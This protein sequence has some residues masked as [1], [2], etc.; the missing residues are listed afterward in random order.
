MTHE[1]KLNNYRAECDETPLKLGT[2]D[3][4][5]IEQL[6]VTLGEGWDGLVVTAT[7]V[8][9]YKGTRMGMS[10]DGMINVPP[11]ATQQ[12]CSLCNPGKIVFVGTGDGVQRITTNLLYYVDNHAKI[13]GAESQPTPDEF[14]QLT[15]EYQNRLDKA[16]PPDG[17]PGQV[18]T[19]TADGNAWQAPQGGGGGAG[20]DGGY[21]TPSIRQTTE[22]TAEFSWA[23]SDDTMPPVEPVTL[24]L[25]QGEPG[26]DGISAGFGTIS[27][28]ATAL[29]PGQQP[30]VQASMDGPDAAKNITL[31]F[32]IPAGENGKS[33]ADAGFGTLSATASQL[34]AGSQPTVQAEWS[35]ENTAK[36]LSFVFGIPSAK[37]EQGENV[38]KSP[39][40]FDKNI[41][42]EG[43]IFYHSSSGPSLVEQPGGFYAY[44]PLRGAGTYNTL[45]AVA[46]SDETYAKR[47]PI[48]NENK[49]FIQNVQ[50]ELG[51]YT[52]DKKAPLSFV[53]SKELIS[54]GATFYAFDGA[55]ENLPNLMIVKDIPYPN[56]YY[57]YG[58]VEVKNSY[59]QNSLNGKIGIFLGD[60]ICAG[61][62]IEGE[63][64]GYGWAGLIGEKYGLNWVNLGR[65]GAGFISTISSSRVIDQQI[66]QAITKYPNADFIIFE[67]GSNDADELGLENLGN[68]SESW[69]EFDTS[70]FCGAFEQSIKNIVNGFPNATFLYIIPQKMGLNQVFPEN[71]V[72]RKYFDSAIQICKKWGIPVC[73][74]WYECPL[75]PNLKKYWE[76][77]S[78]SGPYYVDGQHLTL[79]GYEQIYPIIAKKMILETTS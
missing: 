43:K 24:T 3:S 39:N 11:E 16:V 66:Q 29:E 73:D 55:A 10:E 38:E 65:N 44:V 72:R 13:E 12:H 68:T 25:P 37:E 15:A 28:S 50:G 36:N 30:T 7:F 53:I 41:A 60:S 1:I 52:D 23:A 67:G 6:H 70:T 8:P 20:Q 14:A 77:G 63:K 46:Y 48:L 27:A 62:T 49:E 26:Q 78:K 51:E 33:G 57:P 34:P 64:S 21:Y 69:D 40:I 79:K 18:L 54:S 22:D 2:V 35:G 4:Y 47:V 9:R 71:S 56:T 45:A 5:G 58:E 59:L 32:G 61:T 19:K 76:G 75:N 17:E 74:L 31:T 42:V